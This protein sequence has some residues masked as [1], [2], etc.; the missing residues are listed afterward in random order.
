[1][2]INYFVFPGSY[3]IHCAVHNY[4]KTIQNNKRGKFELKDLKYKLNKTH[5]F[6][7]NSFIDQIGGAKKKRKY[8]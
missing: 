2:N 7:G 4:F 8:E 5:S 1:M 3:F 6:K